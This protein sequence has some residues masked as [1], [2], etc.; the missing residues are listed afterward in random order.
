[1]ADLKARIEIGTSAPV[2]LAEAE[3]R[4][5]EL[6]LEMKKAEYDLAL[7]RGRIGT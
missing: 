6:H 1:M 7:I 5:L 3:V 2:E 4:L